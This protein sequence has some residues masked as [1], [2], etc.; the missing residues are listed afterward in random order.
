MLVTVVI[1]ARSWD[2]LLERTIERISAQELPDGLELEIVVGLGG[3]VPEV[4]PDGVRIVPN[5][6]GTTPDGLNLAIADARGDVIVRVDSRCVLPPRYVASIV[7]ELADPRVGCVGGAQLVLD[8]GR[9][10]SAYAI[11][12]NSILLGPSRYRFSRRSGLTESPY[13]GAWRRETLERIGGF[14]AG[15]IRN[16]DNELADRIRGL[17]LEVR[18]NADLVVGYYNGRSFTQSVAHHHEFGYWRMKQQHRGQR[19]LTGRH[20]GAIGVAAL[21]AGGV[22]GLLACR[23]TRVAAG[24]VGLVT[25]LTVAMGACLSAER[26]ASQRKDLTLDR[27]DPVGV[28][29]A[30]AVAAVIDA[31]WMSGLLRGAIER[32]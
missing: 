13:L 21:V 6:S 16:Q 24:A 32:D 19:G 29:A 2:G 28:L 7:D 8:R 4:V 31:G 20:V 27:F 18:Y 25:Y 5:A 17:G 3:D 11:A 23:K 1:P 14:D 9:F 15:L 12:F 10:G 26:M 22:V 30:P